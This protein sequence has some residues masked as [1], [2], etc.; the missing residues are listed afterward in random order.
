MPPI[1]QRPSSH[2]RRV[3]RGAFV[4]IAAAAAAGSAE[5]A[6]WVA[7]GSYLVAFDGRAEDLADPRRL[8]GPAALGEDARAEKLFVVEP[9]ADATDPQA[10]G[11][12]APARAWI[13][14]KP[15]GSSALAVPGANPWD[16]AHAALAD[17]DSGLAALAADGRPARLAAF[18][19]DAALAQPALEE[20][21]REGL[22]ALTSCASRSAGRVATVCAQPSGHWPS[23]EVGWHAGDGYSQLR[24]AQ[25]EVTRRLAGAPLGVR[26]VHFDTG[27]DD[28]HV[29]LPAWLDRASS[30]DF[31][32]DGDPASPAHDPGESCTFCNP[33]HG[34]GTLSLLAGSEMVVRDAAGATLFDGPLGGAPGAEVLCYRISASVVHLTTGKMVRAFTRAVADRA[35]VVSMSMGGLPSRALADAVDRAYDNGVAMFTAAGDFIR[36]PELPIS[37]PR[38]VVYPARFPRVVAVTGATAD[39]KT[40]AEAPLP[41]APERGPAGSWSLRGSY[42]PPSVMTHALAGFTPNVPWAVLSNSTPSNLIDL[43][44]A[45]TSASTPQVA[46]AA[47]LWLGAHRAELA[48]DWRGWRKSE[49][50]YRALLGAAADAVP[51]DPAEAAYYRKYFGAGL[52]KAR[53]ALDRP[54]SPATLAARPKSRIGLGWLQLVTSI[55]GLEAPEPGPV[56]ALRTEM[57]RTEAAQLVAGSVALQELLGDYDLDEP[58]PPELRDRFLAALAADP[59]ASRT[60]RAALAARP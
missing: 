49:A 60:L 16:A 55:G 4:L 42:G 27:F 45:G 44:G 13:L 50:V 54:A 57:L 58:L 2:P 53:S 40:Y 23:R 9:A 11:T 33:G 59:L 37:S 15:A 30:L 26:V 10:H 3:A 46:A 6:R 8:L 29:A 39:L 41:F 28:D 19:P 1:P 48:G 38:S 31:T 7:T 34:T 21:E 56:A 14:W 12:Q 32:R 22:A 17:R 25:A 43:D 36:R 35:D 51:A 20:A 52:L 5:E 47:A 18:E 24:A